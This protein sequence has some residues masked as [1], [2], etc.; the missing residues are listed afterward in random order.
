MTRI[1]VPLI[2]LGLAAAC[3]QPES[4]GPNAAADETLAM[5]GREIAVT[6]CS[7]CH[8]IGRDDTSPHADAPPFRE[9][10]RN[11]P[12]RALEEPLAEGI[13]VGHPDM[14]VFVF[15]PAEINALLNYLE[16]IQ[17]PQGT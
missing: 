15:Q 7:G 14:P 3:S 9:L 6:H 16:A 4:V 5:T 17:D 8:A 10:S 2:L 12:V 1:P 11:Y 13:V